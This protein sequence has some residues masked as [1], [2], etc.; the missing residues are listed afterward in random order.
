[1][2]LSKTSTVLNNSR[3]NVWLDNS[4]LASERK[5]NYRLSQSIPRLLFGRIQCA[6]P[7]QGNKQLV[8]HS[9]MNVPE[10]IVV[11]NRLRIQ[12]SCQ[13]QVFCIS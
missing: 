1:M 11:R 4:N 2:T 5:E 10:V 6:L 3:S 13:C 9:I 8:N 12:I 7:C